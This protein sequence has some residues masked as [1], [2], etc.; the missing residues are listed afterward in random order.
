MFIKKFVK[1]ITSKEQEEFEQYITHV[2]EKA[3]R[4]YPRSD[5]LLQNLSTASI[6]KLK[7][8]GNEQLGSGSEIFLLYDK[9]NYLDKYLSRG[10]VLRDKN[11]VCEFDF[12]LELEGEE[13]IVLEQFANLQKETFSR[14]PNAQ[15]HVASRHIIVHDGDNV[16]FYLISRGR[17]IPMV[18]EEQFDFNFVYKE[19]ENIQETAMI[20]VTN[21]R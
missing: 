5:K 11:D 4:H 18:V 1:N 17:L 21:G 10:T 13:K 12:T 19:K 7:P 3:S 8:E 6:Y 20:P 2:L 16:K 9:E 14:N 15:I